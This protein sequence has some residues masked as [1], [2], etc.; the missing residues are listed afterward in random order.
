MSSQKKSVSLPH[1]YRN[2]HQEEVHPPEPPARHAADIRRTREGHHRRVLHTHRTPTRVGFARSIRHRIS[3]SGD[4]TVNVRFFPYLRFLDMMYRG[5]RD[6]VSKYKRS[7]LA[8]YNR[9]IWDILY[10]RTFPAIR[11]GFTDEVREGIRKNLEQTFNK[12]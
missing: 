1:D 6:R 12:K 8:L 7:R 5:R 11:F 10:R 9:V 3:S 2:S 4:Y